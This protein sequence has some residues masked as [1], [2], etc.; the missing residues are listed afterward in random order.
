M[1]ITRPLLIITDFPSSA[2]PTSRAGAITSISLEVTRLWKLVGRTHPSSFALTLQK[3]ECDRRKGEPCG[4]L[5]ALN[6]VRE[7]IVRERNKFL[8]KGSC[9]Y[10]TLCHGIPEKLRYHAPQRGGVQKSSND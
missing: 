2:Y 6:Y 8:E 5:K 9:M 10:R 1:A 3:R 7:F 4:I